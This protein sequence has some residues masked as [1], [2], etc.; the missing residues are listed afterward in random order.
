MIHLTVVVMVIVIVIL[1]YCH[2][3]LTFFWLLVLI[4]L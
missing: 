3:C 4:D 1:N 2:L